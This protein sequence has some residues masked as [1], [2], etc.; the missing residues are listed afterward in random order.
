MKK[1]IT[2]AMLLLVVIACKKENNPINKF[3]EAVGKAKEVKQGL[4]NIEKMAKGAEDF[5]ENFE[6]LSELTPITKDQIKTWMP[7]SL[8]DLNR[9]AYSIGK[10]VIAN[11]VDL[12]YTGNDE[13]EVKITIIDGAGGGSPAISMFLMAQN[14]ETDSENN[15]GYER[16]E[17]FDGQKVLAKYTKPEFNE[18][19]TILCLINKRFGIEAKGKHMKPEELWAYIKKL[20]IEKLIN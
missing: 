9:T 10:Q 19:A 3:K 14:L 11:G 17:T 15:S 4:N 1:L 8:G 18:K 5:E 13:K 2:I 6:R 7:E 16:T 12:T 20:E